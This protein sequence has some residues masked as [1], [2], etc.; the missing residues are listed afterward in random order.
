MKKG[1]GGENMFK[2]RYAI[3]LI[4][5]LLLIGGGYVQADNTAT[6]DININV[7]PINELSVDSAG[8]LNIDVNA[9]T[10]DVSAGDDS[11]TVIDDSTTMSYTTNEN[12]KVIKAHLE[13]ENSDFDIFLDIIPSANNDD[14][15]PQNNVLLNTNPAPVISEIS[16]SSDSDITIKYEVNINQDISPKQFNNTVIFTLTDE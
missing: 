8:T 9:D 15:V 3:S 13:K 4:L 14:V 2:S 5:F 1:K 6:Q 16:S 12:D 7:E 10:A 11:F